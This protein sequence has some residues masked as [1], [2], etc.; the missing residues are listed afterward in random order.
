[1]D[2]SLTVYYHHKSIVE[3]C[4]YK[5][6]VFENTT[7]STIPKYL[8]SIFSGNKKIGEVETDDDGDSIRRIK[9]RIDKS[10]QDGAKLVFL[11]P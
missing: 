3:Y 1:M 9:T 7:V 11:K 10:E 8:I 5:I 4:G 2:E 6:V